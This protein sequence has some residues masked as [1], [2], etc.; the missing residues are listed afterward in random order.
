MAENKPRPPSFSSSSGIFSRD[1]SPGDFRLK[2][3]IPAFGLKQNQ[4]LHATRQLPK[5]GD[6]A[7]CLTKSHT[8]KAFIGRVIKQQG[9]RVLLE[10]SDGL[11]LLVLIDTV[12]VLA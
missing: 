5:K 10:L 2:E 11:T 4:L 3:D 1:L 9:N 7:I 8:G 12:L 6:L